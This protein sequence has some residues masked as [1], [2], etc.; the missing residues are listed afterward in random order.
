M[1]ETSVPLSDRS[2]SALLDLGVDRR[3]MQ[4]WFAF[5]SATGRLT[6]QIQGLVYMGFSRDWVDRF[7]DD[8]GVLEVRCGRRR[9]T[10]DEI[11]RYAF[12]VD[13]PA[14]LP[15]LT[16]IEI[17]GPLNV[18]IICDSYEMIPDMPSSEDATNQKSAPIAT[19]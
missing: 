4:P 6:L 3:T 13:S 18:T 1:L 9:I 5:D 2:I 19:D 11:E 15:E 16:V 14:S 17:E 8:T 7:S 10:T 12:L